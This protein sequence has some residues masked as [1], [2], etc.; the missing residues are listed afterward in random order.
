MNENVYFEKTQIS[1]LLIRYFSAIDDKRLDLSIIET[2]FTNDVRILRPNGS[3]LVG[4]KNILD[5]QKTSFERFKATHHVTTDYIIDVNEK[6]ATIRTN[7]TAMHLW[8][9][10]DNNP[11]LNNKH[12]LAGAI[13][14]AKVIKIDNKWR[15]SELVNKN[16]WRTGD[17]MS[18]MANFE[19]PK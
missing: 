1:D 6:I 19:R 5:S 9:D 7:L 8:A 2:T 16:V 10:D 11:S 17:G 15:I 4:H 3:V 13:V 18:E 14:F 12:F